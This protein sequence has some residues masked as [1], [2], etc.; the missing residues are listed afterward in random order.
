MRSPPPICKHNACTM[1]SESAHMGS[2]LDC[3]IVLTATPRPGAE[4]AREGSEKSFPC[5]LPIFGTRA[6]HLSNPGQHGGAGASLE[7]C[8]QTLHACA[9]GAKR[10][11]GPRSRT[12]KVDFTP[13]TKSLQV[14]LGPS[15]DLRDRFQARKNC[16]EDFC[17]PVPLQRWVHFGPRM[18]AQGLQRAAPSTWRLKRLHKVDKMSSISTYH[19]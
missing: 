8:W 7:G 18:P 2:V 1:S 3:T 16:C 4:H 17:G 5:L 6:G 12:S 11:F 9:L 10:P 15:L 14:F 19:S 13:T